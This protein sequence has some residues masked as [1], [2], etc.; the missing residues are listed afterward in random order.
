MYRTA[1]SSLAQLHVYL[2]CVFF[3]FCDIVLPS[4]P[5]AYF[6]LY[7]YTSQGFMQDFEL[8]GEKRDGSRM[9][10]ACESVCAY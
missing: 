6:S 3:F 10:V 8:G 2:C 5:P 4:N 1:Y 9:I 7:E